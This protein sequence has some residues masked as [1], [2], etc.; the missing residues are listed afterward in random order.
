V[1]G[2]GARFV[3]WR[4]PI[5]LR[6]REQY[7]AEAERKIQSEIDRAYEEQKSLY[8]FDD[9]TPAPRDLWEQRAKR[10]IEW[11]KERW[12][13]P[14]WWVNDVVGWIEVSA[15]DTGALICAKLFLPPKRFSRQLKDKVY[16]AVDFK[17]VYGQ[18]DL[19]HEEIRKRTIAAVEA[20]ARH[21]R[22]KKLYVDL[23]AWRRLV[24]RTDLAGI[25]HDAGIADLPG[26][27]PPRSLE[28]QIREALA[29]ASDL[30]AKGLLK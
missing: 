22:L 10:Y 18:R 24:A 11:L 20:L 12:F 21:Y 6:T 7:Y 26:H 29:T 4:I 30:E 5:Y 27:C 19:D 2:G 14:P 8:G 1:T 13:P 16:F 28:D 9:G 25:L 15:G 3:L 17:W 23:D